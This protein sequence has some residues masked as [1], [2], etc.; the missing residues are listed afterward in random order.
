MKLIIQIPCFNEAETLPATLADLPREV[1]G[2]DEVEWLVVDDG[3]TDGTA[4][5]ARQNGVD[6]VVSLPV[7]QGLAKAFM[8]GV[9]ASL[10]RGA[11]VIVN[12]DADN[13]YDARCIADLTKPVL[14]HEAEIVVGERPISDVKEFSP[15]KKLLQKLGSAVVRFASGARIPDAPSGFRAFHRDAAM[16]LYVFNNYTYTLETIIQAGRLNIPITSVPIRV[17]PMT[18]PS[19]LMSSVP[20]YIFRSVSTIVR[21][22]ILYK[23]L[24]FFVA[25]AVLV[26]IP[27]LIAVGRFLYFYAQ[28]EGGGHIQSLILA[29]TLLA[30][31]AML[32]I[33]GILADLVAANRALLQE[34][35]YRQLKSSIE[36]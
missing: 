20:G 22:S 28:G 29:G 34:L 10:R 8:R 26:A 23:P 2:F 33:G 35:R 19:R 14:E 32:G 1:P 16:R 4:E 24:R 5:I 15:L 25:C 9:E 27:G 30:S 36:V 31:A 3:S 13:Q 18:R 7:N 21:I 17:N 11:D 12:T 6:H